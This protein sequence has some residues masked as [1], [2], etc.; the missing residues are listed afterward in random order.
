MK[1]LKEYAMASVLALA[2]GAMV[3]A[4]IACTNAQV[5]QVVNTVEQYL[6]TALSIATDVIA[7]LPLLTPAVQPRQA[8]LYV[9]DAQNFYD[10]IQIISADTSAYLQ[11]KSA[12]ALGKVNDAV[13]A[14]QATLTQMLGDIR[15]VNPALQAKITAYV[16][17][18]A[19]ILNTLA[20]VVGSP[21]V[22]LAKLAMG[23]MTPAV[24]RS[25]L[26][27]IEGMAL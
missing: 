12:S 9:T 13:H 23:V 26:T 15:I 3:L 20:S 8:A 24:A 14:A 11:S 18:A 22:K 2:L 5:K 1:T 16:N 4:P 7:M 25:K 10:A 17:L 27:A 19:G 6:P 21:S